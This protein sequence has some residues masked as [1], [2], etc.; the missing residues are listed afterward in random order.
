[1]EIFTL[2]SDKIVR[3]TDL[4]EFSKE[5]F[6]KKKSIWVRLISPSLNEIEIISSI[7]GIDK[8]EFTDFME[9]DERSRV[10]QGKFLQVIYRAPFADKEE[11]NTA[12][13]SMFFKDKILVTIEKERIFVFEK[14][15]SQL[16]RGK[17][18]YLLKKSIG[19]FM[20]EVFDSVNDQFLNS[21]QQIGSF[22]KKQKVYYEDNSEKQLKQIYNFNIA[23]SHFNHSLVANLEVLNSLRKSKM[24]IFTQDDR[25]EFASLYYDVL[26]IINTGK[27]ERDILLK[28]F[29]FLNFF[30]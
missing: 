27:I 25:E 21:I 26:Q 1:M 2:K 11:M 10:E 22:L 29:N 20:Q 16:S 6:K 18:K 19:N 17:Y 3:T 8:E 28:I 13:F 12:S 7:I 30:T 23:L 9:D 14:F 15:A 4:V 5:D 24:K